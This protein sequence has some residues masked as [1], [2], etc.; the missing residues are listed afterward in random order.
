M[1]PPN[2]RKPFRP[3]PAG[4]TLIELLVVITI[5]AILAG[6]SFA[7]VNGALKSARKAEVR[8]M[9]TQIKG[10]LSTYYADYGVWPAGVT[11][12]DANFLRIMDGSDTNNNR[13]GARYLE[14][15]PKFTNSTGIVTP[16]N[17][18]TAG[19]SNFIVVLDTNYDGKIRLPGQSADSS[20]S[21]AVY[22]VDPDSSTKYI[23][24]W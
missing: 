21:A 12:T 17:F 15:P 20:G 5:I 14:V 1:I 22:A 16:K 3:A 18:Y 7:G 6:L 9:A 8:A 4:F 24:T 13:R 23:G 10:A 2:T 11:R 19:Q